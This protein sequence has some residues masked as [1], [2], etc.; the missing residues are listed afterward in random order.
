MKTITVA[1]LVDLL[2]RNIVI[3]DVKIVGDLDHS[4]FDELIHYD[5]IKDEMTIENKIVLMRCTLESI[6][7]RSVIFLNKFEMCYCNIQSVGFTG[8]KF[9]KG[10]NFSTTVFTKLVSFNNAWFFWTVYFSDTKFESRASFNF[11]VFAEWAIFHHAEFKDSATFGSA[12]FK[13]RALFGGVASKRFEFGFCTFEDWFKFR[14]SNELSATL[15]DFSHCHFYGDTS[16]EI[17]SA[18]YVNFAKAISKSTMELKGKPGKLNLIDFNYEVLVSALDRFLSQPKTYIKV[19]EFNDDLHCLKRI[20]LRLKINAQ[21]LCMRDEEDFFYREVRRTETLI[22]RENKMYG[23]YLVGKY[24]LD[25]MFG[26]GTAPRQAFFSSLLLVLGYSLVYALVGISPNITGILSPQ[27]SVAN[28]GDYLYFS[29]ITFATVG[30]GD[31]SPVGTAKIFA[32]TEGFLG[33]FMMGA[34]SV[35]FARKLLR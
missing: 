13:K 8:A 21:K 11:T 19:L 23:S 31:I 32:A 5:P 1:E 27:F 9:M 20:Q 35:T 17:E 24:L 34:F 28:L 2:K 10:A 4:T 12:T 14:T 15:I 6:D 30:Y 22:K 18:Q 33:V 16:I 3:E 7:L 25:P 29:V 26:Y